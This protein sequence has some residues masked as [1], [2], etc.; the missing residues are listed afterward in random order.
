MTRLFSIILAKTA[1]KFEFDTI[2]I[3]L[4]WLRF[5]SRLGD[6]FQWSVL[7]TS[8]ELHITYAALRYRT[9]LGNSIN[10]IIIT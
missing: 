3:S 2:M 7:P 9:S 6:E 4:I 1:V 8:S 5:G 10:E